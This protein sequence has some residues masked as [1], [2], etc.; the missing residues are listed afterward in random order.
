MED[1]NKD[2]F[3]KIMELP[4][5]RICNPFYKKYKENGFKDVKNIHA[6]MKS[7]QAGT[8]GRKRPVKEDI[9]YEIIL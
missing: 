8:V 2:I 4:V 7:I 1:N 9:P 6:F 3:D 5:L